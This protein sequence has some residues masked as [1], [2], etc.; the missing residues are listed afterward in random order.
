MNEYQKAL[1]ALV[2][3]RCFT[4]HGIGTCDDAEPGDIS[5]RTWTCQRC[6]G[7]GF[8]PK[9]KQKEKKHGG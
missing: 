5:F 9:M 4:C 6:N 3:S 2:S 7:T 1:E 8:N